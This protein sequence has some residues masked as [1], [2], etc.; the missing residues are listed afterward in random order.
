VPV[1]THS[2]APSAWREEAITDRQ[3]TGSE[4]GWGG[5][6]DHV[7]V[8]LQEPLVA[9]EA[10]EAILIG[11]LHALLLEKGGTAAVKPVREVVGQSHHLQ[12][13]PGVQELLSR[14]GAPATTADEPG[15]QHWAVGSLVQER[16]VDVVGIKLPRP[17][18]A[19][20]RNHAHGSGR[21]DHSDGLD[22]VAPTRCFLLLAH[23]AAPSM[24]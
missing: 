14:T 12:I 19:A 6:E 17:L 8:R 9:V 18:A 15:L 7:D 4:V 10:V 13:R 1:T 21:P 20:G 3:P 16:G 2:P 22:E 23:R 5:H 24:V 11:D